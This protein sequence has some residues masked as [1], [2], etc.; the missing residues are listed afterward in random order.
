MIILG[1][2]LGM[3]KMKI[4]KPKFKIQQS[5][6]DKYSLVKERIKLFYDAGINERMEFYGLFLND[7][8]FEKY[9]KYCYMDKDTV[10]FRKA[11]Y[12]VDKLKIEGTWQEQ[13]RV[14]WI[15]NRFT[16][17]NGYWWK[18]YLVEL[19]YVLKLAN[20]SY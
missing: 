16:E 8:D 19:W 11:K 3:S 15:K 7:G 18:Y 12:E 5:Q 9:Q 14:L 4:I 20:I 17:Y 1:E 6:I 13:A 10:E 2:Y